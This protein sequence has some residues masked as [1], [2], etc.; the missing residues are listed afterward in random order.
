MRS[1][2]QPRLRRPWLPQRARRF[3]Q[4]KTSGVRKGARSR[5]PLLF[6]AQTLPILEL[7]PLYVHNYTYQCSGTPECSRF[8]PTTEKP[9]HFSRRMPFCGAGNGP[10]SDD[11]LLARGILQAPAKRKVLELA[12]TSLRLFNHLHEDSSTYRKVAAKFARPE[13]TLTS[14]PPVANPAPPNSC[15]T[16]A[17]S[18]P[19]R[20]QTHAP[21]GHRTGRSE[22]RSAPSR[23]AY[24]DA[25]PLRRLR[26]AC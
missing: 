15:N 1:R 6:S 14:S 25:R 8:W 7:C 20:R 12:R 17:R 3:R 4:D 22:L 9:F 5:A 21:G 10:C 23:T 13:Q 2:K 26:R 18:A 16:A 19:D 11:L 24:R